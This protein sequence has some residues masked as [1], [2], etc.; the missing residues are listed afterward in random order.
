MELKET[1]K[2]AGNVCRGLRDYRAGEVG[3]I[4]NERFRRRGYAAEALSAVFEEVFRSGAHRVYGECDPRNERS[5]RL[6]E[7]TGFRREA[8]LRQNFF[9]RCDTQGEP[10]WK[11]TDIYARL[12]EGTAPPPRTLL[13]PCLPENLVREDWSESGAEI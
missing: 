2:V 8:C 9:F 10:I 5:W 13:P 12:N 7:K 11:D 4:A 3:Y 1:G 6:L